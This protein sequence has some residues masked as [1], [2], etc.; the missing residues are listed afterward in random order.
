ME[1][2]NENEAYEI[3]LCWHLE[4]FT[5]RLREIPPE[6]WNWQPELPAPSPR[7]LA[8][9]AWQW[10]RCDRQHIFEP[11]VSKHDRI[12]D[13]P[14]DQQAMCD[15]L[16]EETET[17]RQLIRGL[18]PEPLL[19]TR[20]QFGENPINVRGFVCHMIQ[21]C[22]YKHGQLSTIYFALGL[23]G[24]GPY[25]APFPNRIY[26]NMQKLQAARQAQGG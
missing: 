8:E 9:H 13:P 21:N 23:D 4:V 11:D 24:T 25:T 18:T 26:E 15:V 19:E 20:K 14:A 22:I 2:Q 10:L 1:P 7:I 12:P 17:W 16:A 5:Q 3:L 6:K